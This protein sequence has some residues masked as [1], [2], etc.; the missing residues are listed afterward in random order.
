VF[1][2]NS[3]VRAGAN[4]LEMVQNGTTVL[5]VDHANATVETIDPATSTIVDT[6]ALPPDQAQVFLAGDRVVIFETGTG[7]LWILPL[8]ELSGFD[9]TAPASLSLGRAAVVSVSPS[10]MLFAYSPEVDEVRR[11]DATRSD[12]VDATWGLAIDGGSRN[13]QITSAGDRWAVLDAGNRILYLDGRT[14]D[15]TDLITATDGPR[16]QLP[17]PAS[18][19]LLIGTG[20]DL[21]SVPFSGANPVPLIGDRA[22]TSAAP[23]VLGGCEYGAWSDG[24]A[25][26]RCASDGGSGVE[27]ALDGMAGSA[28]LRFSANAERAV[29]NDARNGG[30]WAV[31][32]G[33]ELIDNW[34]DL[35]VEDEDQEEEQNDQDIPP[36]IDE[37]QKPPVAV[38]DEFGARPGRSTLLPVLLNDY[39]PNADVLVITQTSGVAESIG[40]VDLADPVDPQRRGHR[41]DHIR[42]HHQRRARRDCDGDRH[43]H[44]AGARREFRAGAGAHDQDDGR[45]RRSHLHAGG[46]RLGRSRR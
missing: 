20:S 34:D 17:G 41:A 1:E 32:H 40:H 37:E 9:A 44:R 38:D 27:L 16:L 8:V 6:V 11:V 4:Q 19:R 39:D 28:D 18:D 43:R 12:E 24:T 25:W 2:L 35:I 3:V 5:L 23:L 36:D 10:G 22:G 29:L 33:G 45:G 26:R 21:L 13:Y 46:G 14:V 30:T 7:E 42:L 31:Q 15:L